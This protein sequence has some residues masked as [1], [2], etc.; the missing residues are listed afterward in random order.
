MSACPYC[1]EEN[2]PGVDACAHCGQDLTSLDQ[3]GQ[4]SALEASLAEATI[5]RLRPREAVMVPPEATIE[6]VVAELCRR[7]IGCVLVGSPDRL[8]GIFSE[9]DVLLRVAHRYD[10]VRSQPVAEL[11]TPEPETLEIDSPIAFALNRMSV[12]DFRHLPITRDGR[13]VGVISLRDVLGLL[14]EHYPDLIRA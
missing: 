4:S 6:E 3:P 9:R 11:M 13:L 10:Q 7:R 1:T 2:L 8:V 12:G 5:E 14:G